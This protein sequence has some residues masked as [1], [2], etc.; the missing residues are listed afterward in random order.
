MDV[1]DPNLTYALEV[2]DNSAFNNLEVNVTNIAE[3]TTNTSYTITTELSLDTTYYWRV[4]ANDSEAGIYGNYSSVFNFTIQSFLAITLSP[5]TVAFGT[6]NPGSRLTTSN[7]SLVG[8]VQPFQL[9]NDGNVLANISVNASAMF[10]S[11]SFPSNYYQYRIEE[12]ETGSFNR[13][14]SNVSYVNMSAISSL[15]I[16][17]LRW[18]DVDDDLIVGFNLTVP[19]DALDEPAG[20]K[21]STVTFSATG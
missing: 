17:F 20:A 10:S 18:Q 7:K 11:V 21:S 19:E 15:A 9:R 3:G 4:K 6:Q 8:E 16:V 1:N 5:N 14:L 13:T 12:N 2:D